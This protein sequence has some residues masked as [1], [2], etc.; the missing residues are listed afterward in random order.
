MKLYHNKDWLYQ[1]YINEKLSSIEIS[2]ICKCNYQNILYWLE[3]FKIKRRTMPEAIKGKSF[4]F[5][6]GHKINLGHRHSET[7][8]RK[9]S[10]NMRGEKSH[11]FGKHHTEITKK[12]MSFAK[13]GNQSFLGRKHS[14]ES[15]NK[16]S[17]IHGGEKNPAWKGGKIINPCG[18]IL[19]HLPA[20]PNANKKGYIAEHRLVMEKKLGRYLEPKE[21][22]HHNNKIT[23]DNR[24]EN[25]RL[26]K[27]KGKH[28][29]YHNKQS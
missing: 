20:H 2:K 12:K 10:E 21:V 28:L 7:T 24:P 29:A 19:I 22:V 13:I 4:G 25:L 15:I 17:I 16:M 11:W 5:Y 18:Y 9:M 23:D 3:N 6:I 1:K 8:K 14:K 27:S 26:F